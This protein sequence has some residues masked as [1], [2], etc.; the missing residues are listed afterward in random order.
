MKRLGWCLV[1]MLSLPPI[2]VS[3][4]RQ[5]GPQG[6]RYEQSVGFVAWVNHLLGRR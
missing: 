3:K 2:V 1:L 5:Q 4:P 6:Q